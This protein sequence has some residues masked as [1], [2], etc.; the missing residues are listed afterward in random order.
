[1]PGITQPPSPRT[2]YAVLINGLTFIVNPVPTGLP[3]QL[4]SYQCHSAA[5]FKSPP[6]IES[7]ALFPLQIVVK[8]I[9]GTVGKLQGIGQVSTVT[10]T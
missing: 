7:S 6:I 2:K 3:S 8:V 9:S 10:V 1:M 5:P 4:F